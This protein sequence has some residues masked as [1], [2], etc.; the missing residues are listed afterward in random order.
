MPSALTV[1]GLLPDGAEHCHATHIAHSTAAT[2]TSSTTPRLAWFGMP[3]WSGVP[4]PRV[5]EIRGRPIDRAMASAKA[6]TTSESYFS[7]RPRKG[8]WKPSP[9]EAG[10]LS[11]MRRLAPGS[12]LQALRAV[13]RTFRVGVLPSC[14]IIKSWIASTKYRGGLSSAWLK[15]LPRSLSHNTCRT[16]RPPGFASTNSPPSIQR[17]VPPCPRTSA[18]KVFLIPST[19]A[20]VPWPSSRSRRI[21]P[22]LATS[23]SYARRSIAYVKTSSLRGL[24]DRIL[25]A[26]AGA[27]H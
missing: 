21:C 19:I 17:K 18:C 25:R 16:V 20:F 9:C 26:S 6:K 10:S 27:P 14:V 5:H 3:L 8:D 11:R 4:V 24:S 23:R 13:L 15:T 22:T 7:G 12:S 2:S 1:G